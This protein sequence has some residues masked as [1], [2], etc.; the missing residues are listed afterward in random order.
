MTDAQTPR[1]R[2][3]GSWQRYMIGYFLVY[4]TGS[5]SLLVALGP[6]GMSKSY[7]DEFKSDHDRY[8][9][10]IKLEAHK[11]WSQRPELNP[12]D[13]NLAARIV[14]VEEYTSRP[15]FVAEQKRRAIY[16]TLID[17]FKVAMVIILVVHFA[18]KP[19]GELLD[20]T[21]ESVRATMERAAHNSEK[22]ARSRAG[23]QAKLDGLAAQ[24]AEIDEQTSR[25]IAEMRR[26]DAEATGQ[27]LSVFNRETEDRKRNEAAL[28]QREL[29]REL[30]D[31]AVTVLE[32]R[33]RRG[34]AQTEGDALIDHFVQRLEEGR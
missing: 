7:L 34:T 8:L 30:V 23:A 22:A 16:G 28:A 13:E 1:W 17:L 6:V 26:E 15:R 9:E 18:R 19:L 4:L 29:K 31:Q 24:Q 33:F 14:F 27:R 2:Q 32:E 3:K 5:V 20:N 25:R 21:I 10:T 11:R 12:P